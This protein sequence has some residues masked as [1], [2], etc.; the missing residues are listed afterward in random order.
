[1]K[2]LLMICC[3]ISAISSCGIK[4]REERITQRETDLFQREQT[5]KLKE[6]E[7]LK[8]EENLKL[9]Q[10]QLDSNKRSWDSVG[11]YN[12]TLPGEWN[13]IMNCMETSCEGSAIGD[14]KTEQWQIGYEN[15]QV[16]AKAYSRKKL[17]RVYRGIFNN[18]MLSLKE[19]ENTT[20]TQI[21][22]TLSPDEKDVNKMKG[23]RV[24]SQPTCRI[25][26]TLDVTRAGT[27]KNIT[28]ILK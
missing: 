20:E 26:Y 19:Q 5:V 27:A 15:N 4:E 2:K 23:S 9:A 22:V 10:L 14:S 12:E 3:C 7:L 18:N 17:V 6:E 28:N 1:M 13:V 24:I 25:V 11:V 21:S 8:R 16:V